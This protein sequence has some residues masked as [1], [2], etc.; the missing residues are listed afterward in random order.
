M[1][2]EKLWA[3]SIVS[4]YKTVSGG[5]A[6]YTAGP[7]F[8]RNTAFSGSAQTFSMNGGVNY[9]TGLVI[10]GFIQDQVYVPGTNDP[11]IT[12]GGTTMAK[13]AGTDDGSLRSSLWQAV[14]SAGN[15]DTLS[16]TA[17]ALASS[18]NI[19]VASAF[20]SGL[21]SSVKTGSQSL[22]YGSQLGGFTMVSPFAINAGGFGIILFG[23]TNS[24]GAT[25]VPAF[26]NTT[27]GAG[28]TLATATSVQI[29]MA[30]TATAT[31]AWNP[32]VTST[33]AINF[34]YSLSA[35]AWV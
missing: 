16:V 10:V 20:I 28:D 3:P 19:G 15:G 33:A 2:K 21:S 17:G 6:T 32:T 7:S 8:V 27:V 26:T 22:P 4:Y 24:V 34:A 5:G 1:L 29:A 13:V 30:H 35:A 18:S 23:T 9:G 25:G 14:V 12:I 11:T 31:G